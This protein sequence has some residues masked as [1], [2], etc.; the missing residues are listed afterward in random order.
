MQQPQRLTTKVIEAT[1]IITSSKNCCFKIVTNTVLRFD[2]LVSAHC[3]LCRVCTK[4]KKSLIQLFL[5]FALFKKWPFLAGFS[6]PNLPICDK[7]L[8]LVDNHAQNGNR[9]GLERRSLV[10]RIDQSTTVPMPLWLLAELYFM[11]SF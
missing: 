9:M 7:C 11:L 1:K 2:C 6:F 5:F 3:L 8:L 4:I 10:I